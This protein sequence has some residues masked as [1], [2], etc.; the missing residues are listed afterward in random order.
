MFRPPY[1]ISDIDITDYLCF[2]I[3]PTVII[4]VGTVKAAIQLKAILA[5]REKLRK[6]MENELSV[7]KKKSKLPQNRRISIHVMA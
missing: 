6:G 7:R 4:V 1:S 2:Q 3:L 5:C